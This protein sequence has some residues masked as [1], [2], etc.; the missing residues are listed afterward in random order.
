MRANMHIILALLA[1]LTVSRV[2]CADSVG[3][4]QPYCNWNT[5][6]VAP[7]THVDFADLVN[8]SESG[9]GLL[10]LEDFTRV[11]ASLMAGETSTIHV[12]AE[13]GG[14]PPL[15]VRVAVYI[16]WNLD[17][18]FDDSDESF[19]LGW[20]QGGGGSG[21]SSGT[22]NVPLYVVD[23]NTRMRVVA[24]GTSGG[25]APACGYADKGQAEDY[26]LKLRAEILFIDGFEQ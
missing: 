17:G 21:G 22:I 9:S 20:L 11:T 10:P 4:P 5:S 12:E 3:F 26:T 2:A 7:I 23:S 24:A 19:D 8:D 6:N 1:A 15:P 14:F 16:D 18:D 25:N 13:T